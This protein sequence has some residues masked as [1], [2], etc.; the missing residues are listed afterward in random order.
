LPGF[1]QK[2]GILK[3]FSESEKNAAKA[4]KAVFY[5]AKPITVSL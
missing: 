2:T 5:D 4:L 1:G 3:P